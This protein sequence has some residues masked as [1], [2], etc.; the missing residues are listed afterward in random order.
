MQLPQCT[1][2]FGD[3]QAARG[4]PVEAVH[5][6]QKRGLRARH[7]QGLDDAVTQAAAP[8]HGDTRGFVDHQKAL[9][10]HQDTVLDQGQHSRPGVP[11]LGGFGLTNRRNAHAVP[12]L[13]AIAG[14]DAA[15]VDAH[16]ALAQQAV[17]TAFGH[18]F[19]PSQQE[20]VDTLAGLIG[21]HIHK[22]D[23][24]RVAGFRNTHRAND[25]NLRA[26]IAACG[27]DC[28]ISRATCGIALIL[29]HIL[30]GTRAPAPGL[31]PLD[32]LQ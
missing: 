24:W 32:Q 23:L 14:L 8:V 5:Q 25:N 11:R 9:F 13:Q 17:N 1:A 29:R 20:I 10:L 3:D 31:D 19:E 7:A 28:Y 18:A 15:L 26:K 21:I 22:T 12:R 2:F 4:I 27:E 6:F 30:L 16:F